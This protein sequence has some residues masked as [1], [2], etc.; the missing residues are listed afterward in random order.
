MAL[1]EA[2]VAAGEAAS[3][4]AV[5]EG[6]P[7]SR[8]NRA[9]PGGDLQPAALGVV[10]HDH[11]ARVAREALR[12]FRGNANSV[13]QDGLAG[14]LGVGQHRGIHVNDHLVALAEGAR[15]YAQV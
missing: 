7:Q 13:V 2:D 12:R 11:P 4:V 8:G 9:R 3:T 1:A 10:A 15:V 14:V 6:T 5:L